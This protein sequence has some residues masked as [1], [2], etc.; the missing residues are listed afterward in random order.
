MKYITQSM[1]ST[2]WVALKRSRILL[3]LPCNFYFDT[4]CIDLS[5][6]MRPMDDVDLD[7][8]L[9]LDDLQMARRIGFV[10]VFQRLH[11]G[12]NTARAVRH[13]G[14]RQAHL[15]ARERP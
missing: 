3:K 5:A 10:G 9:W 6:Q 1:P 11:R 4:D 7:R 14:C 2:T 15:H 8:P 13:T 12:I